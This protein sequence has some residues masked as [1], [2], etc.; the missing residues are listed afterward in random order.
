MFQNIGYSALNGP[1]S[2]ELHN[3][4]H[5]KWIKKI[6]LPKFLILEQNVH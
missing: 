2:Q 1:I 4:Y 6:H 5:L 3:V